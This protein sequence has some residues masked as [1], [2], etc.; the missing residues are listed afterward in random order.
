MKVF[1]KVAKCNDKNIEQRLFIYLSRPAAQSEALHLLLD[2]LAPRTLPHVSKRGSSER[3]WN[4]SSPLQRENSSRHCSLEMWS[5]G[6]FQS[7]QDEHSSSTEKVFVGFLQRMWRADMLMQQPTL[8]TVTFS[9]KW[10]T[11]N[12][13]TCLKS[14][15]A[16]LKRGVH[17]R[18]S[19]ALRSPDFHD[20]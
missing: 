5:D 1:L 14:C 12:R 4:T 9:D 7:I 10:R 11:R 13:L 8:L 17:S 2:N 3:L 19:A 16:Q 6:C 20:L 15:G 18:H